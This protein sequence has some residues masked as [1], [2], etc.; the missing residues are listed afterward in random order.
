M[1]MKHP[2]VKNS[3]KKSEAHIALTIIICTNTVH[4]KIVIFISPINHSICTR[5]K[6]TYEITIHSPFRTFYE[7]KII[8]IERHF[9]SFITKP[10]VENQP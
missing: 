6:K 4:H 10:F 3:H 9:S 8:I 1:V 5:K 2:T 7:G